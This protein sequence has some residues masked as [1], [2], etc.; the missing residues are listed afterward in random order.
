VST[1]ALCPAC[2]TCTSDVR[3]AF[4]RGSPCPNCGL[5]AQAAADV[6]S[7]RARGADAELVE[8][9]AVAVRRA[10]LAEAAVA[11]LRAVLE[12]ARRMLAE[13]ALVPGSRVPRGGR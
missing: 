13:A 10:E 6:L 4:E 8:R 12:R 11:D 2:Q 1:R 7:A 5:S 3:L 9:T